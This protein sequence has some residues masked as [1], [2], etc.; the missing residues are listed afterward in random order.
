MENGLAAW[1]AIAG[2]SQGR[3]ALG[4]R[5]SRCYGIRNIVEFK[6]QKYFEALAL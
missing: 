5:D 4:G 6:I 2:G 1:A 3:L